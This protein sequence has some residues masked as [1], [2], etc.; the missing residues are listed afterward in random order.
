MS[1]SVY[2]GKPATQPAPAQS[3]VP[4]FSLGGGMGLAA[5]AAAAG[6]K[7]AQQSNMQ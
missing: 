7:A 4:N 2:A 6:A 3:P 1:L 5:M